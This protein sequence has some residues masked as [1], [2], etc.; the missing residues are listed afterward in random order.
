MTDC[1]LEKFDIWEFHRGLNKMP[2]ESELH[3][4]PRLLCRVLERLDALLELGGYEFQEREDKQ[5]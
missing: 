5:E 4:I 1:K 3:T 2:Y